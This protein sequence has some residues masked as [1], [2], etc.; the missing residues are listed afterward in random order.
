MFSMK[1]VVKEAHRK[2][3]VPGGDHH[4]ALLHQEKV[5]AALPATVDLLDECCQV[6]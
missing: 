5:S 3:S 6:L 2:S 4:L 1:G